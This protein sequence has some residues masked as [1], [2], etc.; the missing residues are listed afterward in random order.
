MVNLDGETFPEIVRAECGAAGLIRSFELRCSYGP[1][2]TLEVS[3]EISFKT[4][5]V[6][7]A[8]CCNET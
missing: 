5:Q 8:L 6:A 4:V 7:A 1:P 2:L 3:F